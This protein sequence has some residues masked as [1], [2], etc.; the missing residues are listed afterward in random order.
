[1]AFLGQAVKLI[2]DNFFDAICREKEGAAE[3]A[4][5]IE[6]PYQ[7][8]KALDQW[9]NKVLPTVPLHHRLRVFAPRFL[10]LMEQKQ[11]SRHPGQRKRFAKDMERNLIWG[12]LKRGREVAIEHVK[13]DGRVLSLS[14]GKIIDASYKEKDWSLKGASLRGDIPMT[15]WLYPRKKGTMLLPK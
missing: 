15:A 14:E 4:V 2:E 3:T 12:F 11:L 7:S 6:L 1:M 5:D 9:R 10:D 8:K 13:L